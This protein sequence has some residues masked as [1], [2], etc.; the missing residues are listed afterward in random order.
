MFPGWRPFLRISSM[1]WNG[2]RSKT[3]PQKL[4]YWKGRRPSRNCWLILGSNGGTAFRRRMPDPQ[5]PETTPSGSRRCS[6]STLHCTT[7][8]LNQPDP[9][10]SVLLTQAFGVEYYGCGDETAALLT[11]RIVPARTEFDAADRQ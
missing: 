4:K 9:K 8:R 6:E 11:K 2:P 10:G 1:P 5:P 7:H 3:A